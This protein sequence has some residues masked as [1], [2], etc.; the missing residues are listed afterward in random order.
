MGKIDTPLPATPTQAVST[1]TDT[2][3]ISVSEAK[4]SSVDNSVDNVAKAH[5]DEIDDGYSLTNESIRL[6]GLRQMLDVSNSDSDTELKGILQMAKGMG[7]KNKNML[8][9]KLREISY[10]IGASDSG[11][12]KVS[13]I[14]NYMR[15]DSQIKG[16]V[17]KQEQLY[18]KGN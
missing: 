2:A 8:S 6:I 12:E 3:T 1:K 17:N 7:I 13:R 5:R 4:D 10:K 16:L 14:Y 9:A 11:S 15:I 18:A